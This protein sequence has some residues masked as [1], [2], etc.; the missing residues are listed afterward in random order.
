MQGVTFGMVGLATM[1]ETIIIAAFK[2]G[3]PVALTSYAL[4]WWALRNDYLDAVVDIDELEKQIKQ[5]SKDKKK[6]RQKAD[7]VHNKWLAFGG[8]F[9]GVVAL[10]TYAVIELGEIR[11]FFLQFESISA[12]LSGI[13][14]DMLISLVI[15]AFMNFILAIAWPWYWLGDIAGQHIWVWFAVAYGGYW[16]G[17]RLA[18]RR[19]AEQ[20]DNGEN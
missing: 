7:P 9:Y 16:A 3:L 8:G 13:S 5:Q 17:T 1:L 11:D 2:A 12:F 20:G 6:N 19:H 14:F 4:T 15:D 10:L 18:L